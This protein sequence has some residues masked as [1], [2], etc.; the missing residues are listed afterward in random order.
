LNAYQGAFALEQILNHVNQRSEARSEQPSAV[1]ILTARL[2]AAGFLSTEAAVY[3]LNH[4]EEFLEILPQLISAELQQQELEK[5]QSILGA[6]ITVKDG[7]ILS[8]GLVEQGFLAAAGKIFKD[9]PFVFI[10]HG[11]H[12]SEALKFIEQEGWADRIF[13]A[14]NMRDAQALLKKQG[15]TR[16]QGMALAGEVLLGVQEIVSFTTGQLQKFYKQ[17][18]ILDEVQH[19]A[20]IFSAFATAA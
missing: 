16:I 15:A 1:Q 6:D 20:Q 13:I 17:A 9:V 5:L 18:G 7:V 14:D 2:F 3:Y 8:S 10:A 19:W 11:E 12:K 4:R